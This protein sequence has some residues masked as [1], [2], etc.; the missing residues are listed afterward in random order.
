MRSHHLV[1]LLNYTFENDARAMN[2][3]HSHSEIKNTN[4]C[5]K[6]TLW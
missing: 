4:L 2:S 1:F 6:D 5:D 3:H